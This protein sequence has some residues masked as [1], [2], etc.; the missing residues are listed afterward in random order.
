MNRANHHADDV[1]EIV[2]ALIG[3]VIWR[4]DTRYCS[5]FNHEKGK[6][7]CLEGGHGGALIREFDNSTPIAEVKQFFRIL[8]Y[9]FVEYV[10]TLSSYE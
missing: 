2:L 8:I 10:W 7:E 5:K 1:N 6:I 3:G 4:D 9:G